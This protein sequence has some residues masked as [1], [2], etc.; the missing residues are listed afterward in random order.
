METALDSNLICCL[1][2]LSLSP[3]V[4]NGDHNTPCLMGLLWEF[5]DHVSLLSTGSLVI[6]WLLLMVSQEGHWQVSPYGCAVDPQCGNGK[7]SG[8]SHCKEV[9]KTQDPGFLIGGK[10]RDSVPERV[11]AQLWPVRA[12][13]LVLTSRAVGLFLP[14]CLCYSEAAPLQSMSPGDSWFTNHSFQE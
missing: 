11:G 1:T 4:E 14:W 7:A 2:S 3:Y 5:S 10:V 9:I 8:S 6:A 12:L 13:P